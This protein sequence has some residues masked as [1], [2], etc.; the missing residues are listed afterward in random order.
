M[1]KLRKVTVDL[2]IGSD[3]SEEVLADILF[4]Q[5]QKLENGNGVI[6]RIITP[7]IHMDDLSID[8]IRFICPFFA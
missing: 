1:F 7:I 5:L 3:L 8:Y 2:E 6:D 4:N